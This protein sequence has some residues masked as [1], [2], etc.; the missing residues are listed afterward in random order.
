MPT[1][2]GSKCWSPDINYYV[3]SKLSPKFDKYGTPC[4]IINFVENYV[5]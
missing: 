3:I 2:Q 1:K 4:M 5:P